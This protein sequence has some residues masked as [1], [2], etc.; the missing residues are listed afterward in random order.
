MSWIGMFPGQGS[1]E[2]GMGKE[3]LEKYP[4]LLIDIFEESLGWSLQEII[5]EGDAA[6]IKK[7]N[8]AQPYIF[9]ISYCYG[10]ESVNKYGNADALIGHSLGEY[11]AL[12]IIG[13][14]DYVEALTIISLSGDTL[15]EACADYDT[16]VDA[17]LT[18]DLKAT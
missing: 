3:L 10:L 16:G 18:Q 2:P 6:S 12:A 17:G 11:T 1:Q 4:E 8:I 15:H 7:T 9:A 14:F 5:N 13:F